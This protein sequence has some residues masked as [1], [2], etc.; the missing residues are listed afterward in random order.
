MPI[1]I[2]TVY[3]LT[4]RDQ[5]G[6][7]IVCKS[8]PLGTLLKL[9]SMGVNRK[10]EEE[11]LKAFGYFAKRIIEWNVDH[12]EIEQ[13]FEDDE[14]T[15]VCPQCGLTAGDRLPV[16]AKGLACLGID[17]VQTTIAAWIKAVSRVSLPKEESYSDGEMSTETPQT[18]LGMLQDPISSEMLS[19]SSD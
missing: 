11:T 1:P 19:S 6:I 8:A 4:F 10:D 5:P 15:D 18:R 16:T 2:P 14:L 17:F 9:S 7:A 13:E 12:P 3:R